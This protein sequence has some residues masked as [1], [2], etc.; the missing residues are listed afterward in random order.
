MLPVSAEGRPV[1]KKVILNCHD[2]STDLD[3][4]AGVGRPVTSPIGRGRRAIEKIARRVRGY[5]RSVL[6]RLP[7]PLTRI[8]LALDPTSPHRGEVGHLSKPLQLPALASEA[9][10]R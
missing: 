10:G 5:K 1:M 3:L 4:R 8:S 7:P 9:A 6:R 2:I